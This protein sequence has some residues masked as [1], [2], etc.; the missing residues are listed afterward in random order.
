MTSAFDTI[1]RNKLMQHTRDLYGEDEW[2]MTLKLLSHSNLEVKLER[3]KSRPF[4]SNIDTP[5]GDALSPIL[6][7][8]YL[9]FAI[10]ELRTRLVREV[11]DENIPQEIGYADDQD[12][13]S[14]SNEFLNKTE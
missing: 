5:Q 6:F 7:T 9:E 3:I 13:I 10:R 2:L 8:V 11:E 14:R 4:N 1:D 12:F